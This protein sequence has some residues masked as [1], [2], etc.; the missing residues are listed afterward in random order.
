MTDLSKLSSQQLENLAKEAHEMAAAKKE[1]EKKQLRAALVNRIR[2]AG[3]TIG[4]IFPGADTA[5]RKTVK[6]GVKYRDPA[7]PSRTWTGR[8]RKPGWL[9]AAESAGRSLQ[10][11]AV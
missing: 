10:D 2:E 6:S 8:G 9:V 3:F 1:E 11:F 4:D 7:D 5:I